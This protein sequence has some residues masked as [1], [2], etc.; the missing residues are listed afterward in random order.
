MD[1][2][3]AVAPPS[4]STPERPPAQEDKAESAT[5]SPSQAAREHYDR[6]TEQARTQGSQ[7]NLFLQFTSNVK[8]W[9]MEEY[10]PS[11]PFTVLDLGCGRGGDLFKWSKTAASYYC[12]IDVSPVA[13]EEARSRHRHFR[14]KLP[15]DFFVGDCLGPSFTFPPLPS[16]SPF[17]TG[18]TTPAFDVVSCM[19]ALHYSFRDEATARSVLR[20]VAAHLRLGG[21]FLVCTV[22]AVVLMRR[23]RAAAPERKCGNSDYQVIFADDPS[24]VT[25]EQPFGHMYQFFLGHHVEGLGEYVVPG[26]T[27]VELAAECGLELLRDSH[28]NFH[29]HVLPLLEPRMRV[30]WEQMPE[31]QRETAG[32]YCTYAFARRR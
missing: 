2:S 10:V 3:S 23:M 5:A 27:L 13:I 31:P 11:H 28:C 15:A 16:T 26:E 32:L 12:G 19:F 29:R 21:V 22:D 9:L 7:N 18:C 4:P 24:T 8:S 30:L 1:G 17:P 14:H 20:T 25:R 6:V